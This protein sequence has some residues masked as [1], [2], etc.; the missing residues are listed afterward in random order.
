MQRLTVL[1][2]AIAVHA[3]AFNSKKAA[4]HKHPIRQEI[5]DD[6]K[7]KAT[8]WTPK[9]VGDNHMR[10]YSQESI[11]SSMG[12]LGTSPA[13]L[14]VDMLKSVAGSAM[15][16]F[17]KFTSAAGLSSKDKESTF[18][19]KATG[20]AY[21]E[22]SEFPESFSWRTKMPE[23]IGPIEDQGECGSCWAFTS[24]GLL[25]DRFC[26]HTDGAITTRLSP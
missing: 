15:D 4:D 22:S 3:S 12:H 1:L 21:D 7:L 23:C 20:D 9:E 5:V 26:I 17:H 14:G 10:H 25:S 16:V 13:S 2:V 19:L 8:S 24:A 18:H 6:I 11:K